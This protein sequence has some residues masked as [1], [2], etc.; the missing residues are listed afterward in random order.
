MM[1]QINNHLG[2]LLFHL[3]KTVENL[4]VKVIGCLM[5]ASK[6]LQYITQLSGQLFTNSLL[7]WHNNY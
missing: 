5:M 4:P 2:M 3:N 7:L 1:F 6:T